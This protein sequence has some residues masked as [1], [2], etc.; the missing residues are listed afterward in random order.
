M[1]KQPQAGGAEAATQPGHPSAGGKSE[2][3]L[4]HR[5]MSE[6]QSWSSVCSS[7]GSTVTERCFWLPGVRS[8]CPKTEAAADL[9]TGGGAGGT[10]TTTLALPA[11]VMCP[12]KV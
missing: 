7:L 12:V 10:T 5:I 1:Q 9:K 2:M 4:T 8:L 3:R 11:G 6:P